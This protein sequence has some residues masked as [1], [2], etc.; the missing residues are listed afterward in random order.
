MAK[1]PKTGVIIVGCGG[2]GSALFQDLTR[3]LP[4]DINIHLMDGDTAEGKNVH[5][6]MFSKSHLGRNKAM[7]LAAT[8]NTALGQNRNIHHAHFLEDVEQLKLI[9][10]HYDSLILAGCVDNHPAR[11]VM[12]AFVTDAVDHEYHQRT[13]FYVD[14]ANEETKGEVVA[15]YVDRFG[16]IHGSLRSVYDPAVLTD[17]R[18]DPLKK[19]CNQ[20]LDEGN[21]QVLATNRKAAICALELIDAHLKGETPAGIVYFRECKVPRLKAVTGDGHPDVVPTAGKAANS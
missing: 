12:E 16:E 13:V 7:A 8:A 20:Q 15:V 2:I 19:S 3:F 14:C 4:L 17:D 11:R 1:T 5:R 10:R 21:R 9:A 6:Q 18:G